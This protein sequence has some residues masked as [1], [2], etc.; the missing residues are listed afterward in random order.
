MVKIIL[1]SFPY[2]VE[3]CAIT[4]KPS[5]PC[6]T[7]GDDAAANGQNT[8]FSI[9]SEPNFVQVTSNGVYVNT[10]EIP[11][12]ATAGLGLLGSLG[13]LGLIALINIKGEKFSRGHSQ[14]VG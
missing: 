12:A 13:L 5:A 6:S 11:V 14:L 2:T 1:L 7:S 9:K 3:V 10:A 8:D 4:K